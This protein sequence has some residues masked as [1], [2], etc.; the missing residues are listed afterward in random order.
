M[1]SEVVA[2]SY[3]AGAT[4]VP[5]IDYRAARDSFLLRRAH[6]KQYKGQESFGKMQATEDLFQ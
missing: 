6:I 4:Y 1:A 5:S 2:P 3:T